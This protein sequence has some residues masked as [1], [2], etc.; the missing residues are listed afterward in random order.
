VTLVV[1]VG[2]TL[3]PRDLALAGG[4]VGLPPVSQG[5][6]YRAA[7]SRPRAIGI[8]DGYF[9]GA[10]SVWHKEILWAISEGVP[11]FGSASMGALRAAELH[12]FG[13]RGVGRIFEAFRDGALEDD[14]EVAVQHG[15]V[16]IG[17]LAASE[18]MVNIRETLALAETKGILAPESRRSLERFAKSLYFGER[19]WMA[20]LAAAPSIGVAETE[21]AAL[22]NWLPNGRVDQKRLDALAMLAAMQQSPGVGEPTPAAFHFEWTYLWDVF[23]SRSGEYAAGTQPSAQRILDELRI[24]GPD[25]YQRVETGALLRIVAAIGAARPAEISRDQAR[26]TLS[27]IRERL[28]L[29]ARPDLDRWMSANDLDPASMERLVEGQARLEALR[30]RFGPSIGPALLDELRFSGFYAPLAERALK[31]QE[32]VAASGQWDGD[33]A[34]KGL[35]SAALRLWYFEKRLGRPMPDDIADFARRIGFEDVSA[36]DAA[37]Q[38]EWLYL[39]VNGPKP[40]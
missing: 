21:S 24:Q 32:A 29:Y 9:S 31:K 36:F 30:E 23:V 6:V 2:P 12:N 27:E 1:F 10:P 25:I 15:P 11:V 20:L 39:N 13:M 17:Y 38:R 3:E 4:F 22:R 5:D 34:T 35:R 14:D 26:A 18:P 16:E 8:I 7:K 28:G 37:I 19:D 33:R 40:P